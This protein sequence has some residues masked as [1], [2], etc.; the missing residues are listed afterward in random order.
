MDII[1][2]SH[3]ERQEIMKKLNVSYPTIRRALNGETFNARA[4]KIREMAI[5]RGGKI[6]KDVFDTM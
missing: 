2:V 3:G 5:K 4:Q 1:I 6:L